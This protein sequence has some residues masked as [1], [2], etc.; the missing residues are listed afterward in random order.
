MD[1]PHRYGY[2]HNN[3]NNIKDK[4][5]IRL[6]NNDNNDNNKFIPLF[7]YDQDAFVYHEKISEIKEPFDCVIC[8][9]IY[10]IANKKEIEPKSKKNLKINSNNNH[11]SIFVILIGNGIAST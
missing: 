4:K 5:E 6:K 9:N 11:K 8:H 3:K 10:H 1:N 7:K 2:I